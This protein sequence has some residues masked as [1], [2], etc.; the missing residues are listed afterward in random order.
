MASIYKSKA[1]S[2][3]EFSDFWRCLPWFGQRVNL[4]CKTKWPGQAGQSGNF[5]ICGTVEEFG[6]RVAM[7]LCMAHL[8][9]TIPA[10]GDG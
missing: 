4:N 7:K 8:V 6:M 9:S 1:E 5:F 10:L 2:L 3:A